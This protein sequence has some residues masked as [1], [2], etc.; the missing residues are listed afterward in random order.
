M[1]PTIVNWK[2]LIDDTPI[3][4]QPKSNAKNS[5]LNLNKSTANKTTTSPTV[6]STTLLQNNE[7]LD[8]NNP[9]PPNMH[10]KQVKTFA[11]AVSNLCDIPNSQLPQPILKGDNFSIS[12]PEEEYVVGLEACKYTLHARVIWPK[13][14]TPL[15]AVAL[16]TKLSTLWKDLSR[17]GISSLGK[18]FYE[19]TF[20]CLEDVK[21]VRSLPSW[22]LNPGIM[23]LFTWT[24][25]FC[26]SLQNN[27]FE[28]VWVR[29]YGLPQEYWRPM[30]LFAIASSAGTPICT[31]PLAS[32]QEF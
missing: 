1:K 20:S 18:G 14:S 3:P 11:Q 2:C 17:W 25:D 9:K 8:N 4:D 7:S 29:I 22:N 19:L 26:P 31:E 10:Q 30:I 27:T 24:K 5:N 16:R 21:R 13:G 15:T 12:I 23:K 28:Q 32:L 6:A